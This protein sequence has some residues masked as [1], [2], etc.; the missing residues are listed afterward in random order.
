MKFKP[1]L[2][3]SKQLDELS[4]TGATEEEVARSQ[5][6]RIQK[7]QLQEQVK[8]QKEEVSPYPITDATEN[9][10][11]PSTKIKDRAHVPAGLS[12]LDERSSP[13]VHFSDDSA[14][15]VDIF[16]SSE[17]TVPSTTPPLLPDTLYTTLMADSAS[18][19]VYRPVPLTSSTG[20]SGVTSSSESPSSST[21]I[22]DDATAGTSFLRA[23]E[24]ELQDSYRNNQL[25][26][27]NV[28][29]PSSQHSSSLNDSSSLVWIQLPRF[30]EISPL[31][32]DT[33]V[34]QDSMEMNDSEANNS[35]YSTGTNR[36]RNV[37]FE[38]HR[39][40]PGKIGEVK[41]YRSGRMTMTINGCCYDL[42]AESSE[43]AE[44]SFSS[45]GSCC[46]A[47]LVTPESES[48]SPPSDSVAVAPSQATCHL[49]DIL[50]HKL[51]AVPT[52]VNLSNS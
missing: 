21:V 38:L 18:G 23:R 48:S 10:V 20:Q 33:S 43:H 9:E 19:D 27:N 15:L 40:P 31:S 13:K 47:A 34:A 28:I 46:L 37:P 41:V 1:K 6:E 4:T 26:F 32:S 14:T 51:V 42:L 25:L 8:D 49:L 12:H 3:R 24:I 36:P 44:N 39:L 29:Q 2:V 22:Q 50:Q 17:G 11:V 5:W 45:G 7:L 35:R 16:S 30:H 52:I